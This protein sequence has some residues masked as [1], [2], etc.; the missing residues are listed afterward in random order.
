[1]EISTASSSN[2][3]HSHDKNQSQENLVSQTNIFICF[4]KQDLQKKTD[5]CGELTGCLVLSAD[6]YWQQILYGDA[7]STHK[8]AGAC[9]VCCLHFHKTTAFTTKDFTD[10]N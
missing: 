5:C 10:W 1:M 4:L 3:L 7:I 6:S 2:A 9:V 8:L